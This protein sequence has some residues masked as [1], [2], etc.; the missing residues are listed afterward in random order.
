[1]KEIKKV[2]ICG[3]GAVGSIYANLI[4]NYDIENL[5]VLVD[6]ERYDKYIKS[7][8]IFN[9]KELNLRYILPNSND[10]KA[11]LIII[12]TKYDGLTDVIKNIKNFITEDT[13]IL[14]LLNGVTSEGIIAEE[15]G[16][17]HLPCAYFIGHSAMRSG[18]II[19][20]DGVGKIV[21]GVANTD[22]TDR[23][24]EELLKS[25]FDK[26]GINYEVP[27]DI[28]RSLWLKY[29]LNVSSNQISAILRMNFGQ[30]QSNLKYREL[31]LKVMKEVELVAKEI[32]VK[33][34]QTMISEAMITF[35]S[36][37][38][39]GKT[40]M[41]QDIEAG[42]KT[43]VEIFGKTMSEYGKKYNVQTPYN[44]MLVE[45]IEILENSEK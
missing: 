1:M 19:T 13:I 45:M 5:R 9:G 37:L 40:S 6:K 17:K 29:M 34:T 36:M 24:D 22:V 10:F 16:W 30:M 7:P 33:N 3:V 11:D 42:R 15:Y 41:L 44:D 23:N 27:S 28:I 43:E 18:N 39:D 20:H 4:S 25:Y 2:I 38:P 35:D 14:S 31:M 21:F 8:K 26:V 12:A 32:G